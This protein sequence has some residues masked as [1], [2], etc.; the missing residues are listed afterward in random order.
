MRNYPDMKIESLFVEERY[1]D[2][3]DCMS[4]GVCVCVCMNI[5]ELALGERNPSILGILS[6]ERPVMRKAL[7]CY[8]IIMIL[9]RTDMTNDGK[10]HETPFGFFI[11]DKYQLP[12]QY[13]LK[14]EM[15]T[16]YTVYRVYF[17]RLIAQVTDE[18]MGCA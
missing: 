9:P 16:E 3:H 2:I 10:Y 12:L 8:D 5:C 13:I 1:R 4:A 6:H 15:Y 17:L 14:C 11:D 7:Q 18:L